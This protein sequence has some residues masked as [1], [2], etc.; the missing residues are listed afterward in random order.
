MASIA[1][2]DPLKLALLFANKLC[3]PGLVV[4]VE[5]GILLAYDYTII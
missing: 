4:F 1:A 3:T 2:C 5:C